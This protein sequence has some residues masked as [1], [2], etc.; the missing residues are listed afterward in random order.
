MEIAKGF[1]GE[2]PI[3]GGGAC[4][5]GISRRLRH[6][7]FPAGRRR[8]HVHRSQRARGLSGWPHVAMAAHPRRGRVSSRPASLDGHRA[9]ARRIAF[10]AAAPAAGA[11]AALPPGRGGS[12][13]RRPWTRLRAARPRRT[14]G[15]PASTSA[16]VAASGGGSSTTCG[17]SAPGSAHPRPAGDADARAGDERARNRR[18]GH[19]RQGRNGRATDDEHGRRR[20]RR[21]Q[22]GAAGAVK[23][24]RARGSSQTVTGVTKAARRDRLR[25][26]ALNRAGQAAIAML[27]ARAPAR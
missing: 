6:H 18:L 4:R 27:T 1:R 23:R 17:C 3:Q 21:R 25:P 5:S 8:A 13:A 2:R 20:G 9:R 22:P 14:I 10:A 26:R 24:R 16:P 15:S 11:G 12:W 7:R 19:G